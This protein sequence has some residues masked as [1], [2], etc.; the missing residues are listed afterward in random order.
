MNFSIACIVVTYNRKKC[1]KQCLDSISNQTYKPK[2]VYIIDNASTDGTME[3]VKN[4]GYY[5][6]YS[7]K[8]EYKYIL[9]K[10]NEGGAGGFYIGMK[11]AFESNKYDAIWVMDDD[12]T[13]DKDSL[14]YLTHFLHTYDYI[15]PIVLSPENHE[16]CS[17]IPNTSY[18]TFCKKACTEGYV[19]DFASP[20]NGILYSCRLIKQ[21]GYP[22]KEMFLWGDETNYDIRARKIGAYPITVIKAIHY[23]PVDKQKC[24]TLP[25]GKKVIDIDIDWKM[26]CYIRNRI[27]NTK[28]KNNLYICLKS[29]IGTWLT[30]MS[31]FKIRPERKNKC[32]VLDALICGILGKFDRLE[33]YLK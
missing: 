2:T 15:A 23:H 28:I 5:D 25:N 31:Y 29:C 17:F 10:K 22:K 16:I 18:K 19:P 24:L 1:L 13:P 14:K 12:G 7:N 27:Y 8:I 33:K 20:F 4:W 32:L 3:C 9:N 30:Y 11:T 26:Y 6:C 21:I